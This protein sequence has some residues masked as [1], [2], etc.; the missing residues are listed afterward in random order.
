MGQ[1]QVSGGVSVHKF[2]T[3]GKITEKENKVLENQPG[4]LLPWAL[5]DN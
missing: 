1:D 4:L 2:T 3:Y 5:N